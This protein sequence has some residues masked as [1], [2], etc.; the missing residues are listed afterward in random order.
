MGRSGAKLR[1]VVRKDGDPSEIASQVAQMIRLGSICPRVIEHG[2][3]W[4]DMEL[5]AQAPRLARLPG[6]IETA[7]ATQVWHGDAVPE[8]DWERRLFTT[9]GVEVP[10]FARD[11]DFCLTHGDPTIANALVRGDNELVLCDPLSPYGRVPQIAGADQGKILQSMLGWEVVLA[12]VEVVDWDPPNFF[13]SE[14][15][16]RRAMFWC[17]VALLRAAEHTQ[18]KH[19]LDWCAFVSKELFRSVG[20]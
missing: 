1:L 10:T 16:L 20:L 12:G 15:E 2:P 11:P 4:Y 18:E 9:L 13:C 7:L 19:V 3:G 17:A 14:T 6:D 8:N 5:L